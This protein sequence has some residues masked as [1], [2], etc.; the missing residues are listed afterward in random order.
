MLSRYFIAWVGEI[1]I[2]LKKDYIYDNLRLRE[3]FLNPSSNV[4]SLTACSIIKVSKMAHF[5]LRI[6]EKSEKDEI[7]DSN[8]NSYQSLNQFCTS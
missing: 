3:K 8:V 7:I 2:V 4:I 5:A 1:E 6:I